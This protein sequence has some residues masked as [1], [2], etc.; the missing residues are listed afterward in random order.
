MPTENRATKETKIYFRG[1]A[2]ERR[3]ASSVDIGMYDEQHNWTL[4]QR[5]ETDG[6]IYHFR[7]KVSADGEFEYEVSI[8]K[9]GLKR[10]DA[11][12]VRV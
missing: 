3:V 11:E 7:V 6:E 10:D 1:Y 5:L 4:R 12:E 9:V 2:I 8:E